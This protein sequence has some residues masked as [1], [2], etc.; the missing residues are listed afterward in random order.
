MS[1]VTLQVCGVAFAAARDAS[2]GVSM[3]H[4]TRMNTSCH[5]QWVHSSK[6]R[7]ADGHSRQL[8]E[9]R[10]YPADAF[11]RAPVPAWCAECVLCVE[12]VLCVE[13]VLHVQNVLFV[14]CVLS[15]L[16]QSIATPYYGVAT[17]SR[18]LKN[19]CLFCKEDI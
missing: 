1:N 3:S 18:L 14:E 11:R 16:L 6:E 4:V 9:L 10:Q 8:H 7:D 17:I 12:F 19:V 13:C 5:T 15:L 2:T